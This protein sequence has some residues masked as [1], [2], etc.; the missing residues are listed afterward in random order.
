M[1][2]YQ[3]LKQNQELNKG[4][5]KEVLNKL[6]EAS[7][8]KVENNSDME[9]MVIND[10]LRF[11]I[12]ATKKYLNPVNVNAFINIVGLKQEDVK[13]GINSV[14][15]ELYKT[16]FEAYLNLLDSILTDNILKEIGNN[17]NNYKSIYEYNEDEL[18]TP[19]YDN[20]TN[21]LINDLKENKTLGGKALNNSQIKEYEDALNY[22]NKL[23]G[24]PLFN[25]NDYSALKNS[26]YSGINQANANNYKDILSEYDYD[27]DTL[28]KSNDNL[29]GDYYDVRKNKDV[30]YNYIRNT[31]ELINTD[32][33]KKIFKNIL[34]YLDAISSNNPEKRKN[35]IIYAKE[36]SNDSGKI[37]QIL[38]SIKTNDTSIEYS[39]DFGVVSYLSS[40]NNI[41][42]LINDNNW[43]IDKFVE[44]PMSH[45][46][47]LYD[48]KLRDTLNPE[49]NNK[50]LKGI[51]LIFNIG[52]RRFDNGNDNLSIEASKALEL[53]T[54]GTSSDA[55]R[56]YNHAL[57]KSFMDTVNAP[58]SLMQQ[59]K[60]KLAFNPNL[61]KAIINPNLSFND[62]GI[63]YYDAKDSKL[64]EPNENSFDDIKYLR[65]RE[66]SIEDFKKRI[67]DS[68]LRYIKMESEFVT[69][70]KDSNALYL[71]S[72]QYIALAQK[73]T[74]KYLLSRTELKDSAIYK[75]VEDFVRNGKDYINNL[76]NSIP[77]A[78]K[79]NDY[80]IAKDI[81]LNPNKSNDI[82]YNL[83]IFNITNKYATVLDGYDNYINNNRARFRN[84]NS[85]F[86]KD[87]K[88]SLTEIKNKYNSYIAAKK[89]YDKEVVK[90]YGE[91][92]TGTIDNLAN[93]NIK[94]AYIKQNDLHKELVELKNDNIDAILEK[95]KNGSISELYLIERQIQFEN[96][97]Y[98]AIPLFRSEKLFSRD[99]YIKFRYPNEFNELSDEEKDL[100]FENYKTRIKELENDFFLRKYL[101]ANDLAEKIEET[102]DVDKYVKENIDV[103]KERVEAKFL[104]INDDEIKK[105]GIGDLNSDF[106]A[107]DHLT[108]N[109]PLLREFKENIDNEIIEQLKIY[110]LVNEDERILNG[111][112]KLEDVID[113]AQELTL[114]YL[115][116]TPTIN[117]ND[118][119]IIGLNRLLIDGKNYIENL[120]KETNYKLQYDNKPK[121]NVNLS[122]LKINNDEINNYANGLNV[123][124]KYYN[125]NI[126]KNNIPQ[127]AIGS[128]KQINASL[129]EKYEVYKTMVAEPHNYHQKEIDKAIEEYEDIKDLAKFKA[130]ELYRSGSVSKDYVKERLERIDN[131]DFTIPSLYEIDFMKP[132][133][134]YIENNYRESYDV[135]SNDEKAVLYNSYK[136]QCEAQRKEFL[137]KKFLIEH[138]FA[139]Q[140]N[141]NAPTYQKYLDELTDK[142]QRE[143]QINN[144]NKDVEVANKRKDSSAFEKWVNNL[145][146][147]SLKSLGDE[148]Y[149]NK[150]INDIVFDS[151]KDN[152][153]KWIEDNYKKFEILGD[154]LKIVF[155]A[156]KFELDEDD[157]KEFDNL[158]KDSKYNSLFFDSKNDLEEKQKELFTNAIKDELNEKAD[159]IDD[160]N[161]ANFSVIDYTFEDLDDD[162]VE[163]NKPNKRK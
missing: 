50:R 121:L 28:Q 74:T 47:S 107:V 54:L 2:K 122:N 43:D 97:N 150:K 1:P 128:E 71:N 73:A 63:K 90:L 55:A 130:N 159:E 45:I 26:V 154:E 148:K 113:V 10:K 145:K 140:T 86:I 14:P 68:I 118:P 57:Y 75:E 11:F 21:A 79:N 96:N 76:I 31:T 127:E 92:Y 6:L 4:N 59:N 3:F 80:K 40:F 81:V 70:T 65:R 27:P 41:V 78:S 123:F 87:D 69:K 19:I 51:D 109:T 103:N 161:E 13:G 36:L 116:L 32:D 61:D 15:F 12:D 52:K 143:N 23:F 7:N 102:V 142:F 33:N 160:Y 101:E 66:E 132:R 157:R 8:K 153:L 56:A 62:L 162:E 126:L 129:I 18:S 147:E 117:N 64:V 20:E 146:K 124:E 136:R 141:T 99:E 155:T 125:D 89:I 134:E 139:K 119:D 106:D 149:H 24:K 85:K 77:A 72:S 104:G 37:K 9:I 138:D 67:D 156:A 144:V 152:P 93:K 114:K 108:N 38:D 98:N 105:R 163:V 48:E 94:D 39:S 83:N 29:V 44:K 16:H 42:K 158:I 53:M 17:V 95:V 91:N 115:L 110:S 100:I 131:N 120:V 22:A 151:S 34:H 111:L 133:D 88:V 49:I 25:V 58:Y 46:R 60:E 30:D 84:A 82:K 5:Y 35:A 112:P 135:L 137:A